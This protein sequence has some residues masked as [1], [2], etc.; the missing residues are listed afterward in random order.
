ML[1][2]AQ[3]LLKEGT[4]YRDFG[5]LFVVGEEGQSDGARAANRIPNNCKWLINGEPTENKMA[6]GSKGALRVKLT[7]KGKACHSA[8]PQMG[9][10]AIDKL[11]DI[12]GDVR[13][14]KWP[15]HET[16]GPATCNIGMLSGGIQPNVVAPEAEAQ[17]MFRV[18][19]STENIKKILTEKVK[20]R[21]EL[22]FYFG[23]E[24]VKTYV[25]EGF[26]SMIAAYGTDIPFLT[27]WGTPLLFGP[28]SI[29]DAHTAKEKISR[30]QIHEAAN[31]YARIIR[32]LLD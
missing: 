11:L 27:A 3:Q 5:M 32:M 16:F 22:D 2:A 12:L 6:A 18:V 7:T 25:P 8:Y 23:Y 28:G 24:P 14:T 9:E 17:L 21:G 30:A 26:E 1:N 29:L 20:N 15:V 10:S 13:K 4:R 19:S 31:Q